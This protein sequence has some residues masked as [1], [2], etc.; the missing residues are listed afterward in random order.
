MRTKPPVN[1]TTQALLKLIGTI[2]TG[3][4]KW[5]VLILAIIYL[6]QRI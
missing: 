2:I 3:V 5:L 6:W 4:A 1:E